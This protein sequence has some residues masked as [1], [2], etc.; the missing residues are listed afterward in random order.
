MSKSKGVG[1]GSIERNSTM[2][3]EGKHAQALKGHKVGDNLNIMVSGKK[4]SHYQNADGSHSIG[5]NVDKVQMN[6]DPKDYS[7]PNKKESNNQRDGG[8]IA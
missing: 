6:Q 5:F 3:L 7:G 2:N 1:F 4:S 8:K